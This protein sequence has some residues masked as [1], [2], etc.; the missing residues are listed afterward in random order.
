LRDLLY[1]VGQGLIPPV[2]WKFNSSDWI[3][4]VVGQDLISQLLERDPAK[5]LGAH[6]GAEEIKAHPFYESIN[7]A[8]LRNTRPPYI[9]R[10]NVRKATPSPA[11]EA[12]FG[13][14]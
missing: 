13:D 11:A 7:W 12:N 1:V 14:F 2:G 4:V 9:P 3:H 6:A 8:L 10:R 5:R